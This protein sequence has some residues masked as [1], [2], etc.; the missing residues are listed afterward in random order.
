VLDW[1]YRTLI[2]D[3]GF[4]DILVNLGVVGLVIFVGLLVLGIYFAVKHLSRKR[5]LV[6]AFPLIFFVFVLVAN[7]SLS[8]LLESES[9]TWFLGV[10]L[11]V[12]IRSFPDDPSSLKTRRANPKYK[13]SNQLET[14]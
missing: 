10:A 7:I 5:T 14:V 1:S 6:S 11:V 4:I 13:P 9:F 12:S 2:G 8:L 3:N